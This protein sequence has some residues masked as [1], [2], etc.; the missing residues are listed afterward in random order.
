M[1]NSVKNTGKTFVLVDSESIQ[2]PVKLLI[3][4][5]HSFYCLHRPPADQARMCFGEKNRLKNNL[6][7]MPQNFKISTVKGVA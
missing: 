5:G 2:S 6:P 7:I 3:R 1:T 4:N